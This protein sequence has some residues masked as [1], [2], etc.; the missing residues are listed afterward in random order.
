[1]CFCALFFVLFLRAVI[2]AVWLYCPAEHLFYMLFYLYRL[3]LPA[4]SQIN[5]DDSDDDLFLFG[6]FVRNNKRI[7]L[8][9]DAGEST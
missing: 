6:C 5:D 1:V 7:A 8:C 9:L 2:S 4:G 3:C